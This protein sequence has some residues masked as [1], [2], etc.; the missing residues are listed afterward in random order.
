MF[1][2]ASISLSIWLLGTGGGFD[3]LR[4]SI[5]APPRTRMP[6]RGID[7]S[8]HQGVID[9]K[10]VKDADYTF[11][12]LKASEG[13]D[14]R[15]TR[16]LQNWTEANAA[17]LVTG[18]YHYFTFCAPGAAQADH[19]LAVV[20]SHTHV[21]PLGVDV[22]FTGNC[23]AWDSVPAIQSELGAFVKRVEA[24]RGEKLLV[25]TAREQFDELI[26]GS[27]YEHAM[28]IRSLWGEPLSMPWLFWQYSDSGEVP[29]IRGPVDLDVFAGS[30]REW[31]ERVESRFQP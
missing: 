29:G 30:S 17:G 10:A 18:A 5:V 14:F 15:D 23:K 12:Y 27:L 28:W 8:H 21:L 25:Y 3:R 26:P 6:V 9:W 22:E 1:G 4:A 16:F 13:A 2:L 11:A 7:V 24:A 31:Q 19:F 20:S